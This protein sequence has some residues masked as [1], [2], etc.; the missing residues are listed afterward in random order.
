V[1]PFAYWPDAIAKMPPSFAVQ[2]VSEG[3]LK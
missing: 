3:Q 1:G 2:G